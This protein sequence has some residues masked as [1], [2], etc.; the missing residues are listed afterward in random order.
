MVTAA[1]VG[2]LPPKSTRLGM[3]G[4]PRIG[5]LCGR[6][7]HKLASW[8][9]NWS[10]VGASGRHTQLHT[11]MSLW[12]TLFKVKSAVIMHCTLGVNICLTV[13]II[14][15][16]FEGSFKYTHCQTYVTSLGNACNR[17]CP[18]ADCH[19]CVDVPIVLMWT[20][21]NLITTVSPL[22][23]LILIESYLIIL[24]MILDQYMYYTCWYPAG[25]HH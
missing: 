9:V 23:W 17:L 20:F 25:N 12:R 21:V 8:H 7:F 2:S 19:N 1:G 15:T 22:L 24:H 3:E 4:P 14:A 10:I 18:D 13:Y 11:I 16:G 5:N 6:H